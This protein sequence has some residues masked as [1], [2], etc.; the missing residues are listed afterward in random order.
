M[1]FPFGVRGARAYADTL[2]AQGHPL[3]GLS[4]RAR[5]AELWPVLSVWITRENDARRPFLFLAPAAML[6][7]LLYFLADEEPS[8]FA[9]LGALIRRCFDSLWLAASDARASLF[10]LGACRIIYGIFCRDMAHAT[11]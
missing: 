7:V 6:G 9:P 4:L 5:L 3:R 1:K 2:V 10:R 8:I 11:C